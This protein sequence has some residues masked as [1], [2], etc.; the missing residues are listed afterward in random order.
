MSKIG[1]APFGAGMW[2]MMADRFRTS[3]T[4]NRDGSRVPNDRNDKA[5]SGRDAHPD[6]GAPR[7]CIPNNHG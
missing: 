4:E 2:K 5:D 6:R 7:G 3:S 1:F